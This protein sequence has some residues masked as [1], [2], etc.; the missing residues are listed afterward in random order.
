M[1]R[2]S[3]S[4]L[5]ALR[6][7]LKLWLPK[8][9]TDRLRGYLHRGEFNEVMIV[10]EAVSKLGGERVMLDVGAHY[11]ATS[12]LFAK[13]GWRVFA[14]E[15]DRRNR[16]IFE[17]NVIKEP[18]VYIDSRAVSNRIESNQPFFSSDISTGISSLSAFHESHVESDRIDTVTIR[19]F[20]REKS[21]SKIDFLKVDTEGYDLFVLKGIDWNATSP[22]IIVCEFENAKSELLGYRFEQLADL[23]HQQGYRLLIS[24]WYPIIKYGGKHRWR[25]ITDYPCDLTDENGWGNIIAVKDPDLLLTIREIAERAGRMARS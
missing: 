8:P 13:L 25:C 18:N 4:V 23:L 3:S 12:L 15:P 24:E 10:W 9:I 20:V 22:G 7:I 16:S 21:L 6:D 14:F 1:D 2:I 17:H 11:G 19:K 5:K